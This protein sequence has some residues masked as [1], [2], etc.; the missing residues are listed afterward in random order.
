MDLRFWPGAVVMMPIAT[1]T[2]WF[3]TN[4]CRAGAD[5]LPGVCD[6]AVLVTA[7]QCSEAALQRSKRIVQISASLEKLVKYSVLPSGDRSA[8]PIWRPGS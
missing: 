7:R 8:V 3:V 4:G 1:L 5:G 2:A 6:V